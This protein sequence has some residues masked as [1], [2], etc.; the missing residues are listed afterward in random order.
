M[1]RAEII[2]IATAAAI[3]ATKNITEEITKAAV[4][5]ALEYIERKKRKEVKERK[6]WRLRNTQLLLKNYRFLK[7]HCEDAVFDKKELLNESVI[8]ILDSLESN[9]FEKEEFIESIKSSVT[10]TQVIVA[11]INKMVEIYRIY[12]ERS[13]KP[14]EL[15][16]FNIMMGLYIDKEKTPP[17]TLCERYGIEQRTY[18]RDIKGIKDIMSTLIFGIDGLL[19]MSK[20]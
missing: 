4:K 5:A 3:E 9:E 10:R 7:D 13:D 19:A 6:D 1:N 11:H 16:Q 18:Y 15:R 8:D 2:Q 14:E 17:A 12:S 20:R